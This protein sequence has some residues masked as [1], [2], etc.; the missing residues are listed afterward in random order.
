VSKKSANWHNFGEAF[1]R[2]SK[3]WKR[4]LLLWC[5]RSSI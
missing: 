5:L 1:S 3:T 2:I 4:K